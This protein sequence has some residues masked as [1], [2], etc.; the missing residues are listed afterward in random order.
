MFRLERIGVFER[1][2]SFEL[3]NHYRFVFEARN[4]FSAFK[5]IR[6]SQ[7]TF[8]YSDHSFWPFYIPCSGVSFG[9]N[10]CFFHGMNLLKSEASRAE[11]SLVSPVTFYV[12]NLNEI[13]IQSDLVGEGIE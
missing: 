11:V 5:T 6:V 3:T 1:N 7:V 12:S 13:R 10:W 9:T 8:H 2:E 4:R